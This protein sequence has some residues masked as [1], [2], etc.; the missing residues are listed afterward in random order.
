MSASAGLVVG[1]L[2]L[3][4]EPQSLFWLA[5]LGVT[6]Q[7]AG[8]L[9][10]SIALPR[11]PAVTTSIL[12]LVQPVMTV[13]LSIVLLRE[14]PSPTQLLGVTLV[15]GGIAAATVPLARL[16]DGLRGSRVRTR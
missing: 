1:D 9:L 13:V 12:L 15:I 4:P 2:D 10:I 6:S 3:T 16:R 14:N 8:Y 5:L 7:A 11:L